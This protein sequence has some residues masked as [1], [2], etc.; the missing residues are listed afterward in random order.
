MTTE[1]LY[2]DGTYVITPSVI[3]TPRRLYPIVGCTARIRRDPLWAGFFVTAFTTASVAMYGDLLTLPEVAGAFAIS[4]GTIFLGLNIQILSL[5]AIGHPRAFILAPSKKVRLLFRAITL[6]R[7]AE[8]SASPV[9]T[10]QP[11][12]IDGHYGK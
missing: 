8:I 2:D 4:A 10:G 12:V 3:A 7:T 9:V 6:A 11:I 5:D 1:P